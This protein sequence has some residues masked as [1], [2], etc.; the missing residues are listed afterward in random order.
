MANTD[1]LKTGQAG[2][3]IA[4]RLLQSKGYEILT[5]N[6][7]FGKAEVDLIVKKDGWLVFVE[8]RARSSAD[9]GNPEQTISKAKIQ[10]LK[11]AADAYIYKINWNSNVRF[12]IVAIVFSKPIDIQHFEDAFF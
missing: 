4:A 5:K 3:E 6:Y 1:H 10:L 12:D 7:T 11:K 9:Y 2:E 8:V